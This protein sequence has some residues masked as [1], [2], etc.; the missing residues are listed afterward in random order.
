MDHDLTYDEALSK[1]AEWRHKASQAATG[2]LKS[3]LEAVAQEYANSA[4]A[5]QA[6]A[7]ASG[8]IAR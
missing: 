8:A 7:T 1:S 5:I 6:R 3:A 4:A 2:I